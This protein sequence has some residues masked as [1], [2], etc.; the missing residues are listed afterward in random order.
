[1]SSEP[2][3]DRKTYWKIHIR[4]TAVLLAVWFVVGY[5]LSIF[6]AES[7]NTVT[8]LGMPF[9][10]WMAQ[11]GSIFTFIGLILAYAILTGRLDRRAGVE[12][13]EDVPSDAGGTT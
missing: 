7:L 11:Q 2:D 9:G 5:V 3:I 1:M 12:E 13:R 8:V 6:L 10:F 4:R